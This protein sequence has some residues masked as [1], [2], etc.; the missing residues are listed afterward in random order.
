LLRNLREKCRRWADAGQWEPLPIKKNLFFPH[1]FFIFSGF[2]SILTLPSVEH[3]APSARQKTL[4][5]DT[6]VDLFF[7]EC[8]LPNA[9]LGKAFAKCKLGFVECLTLGKAT[10]SGIWAQP[11]YDWQLVAVAMSSKS[12]RKW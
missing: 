10:E 6:F 2:F 5:K 12:I 7:A 3:S 8:P 11:V 1:F 4:D 9:A